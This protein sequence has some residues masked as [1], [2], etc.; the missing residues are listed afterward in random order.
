MSGGAPCVCAVNTNQNL[1][2][3]SRATVAASRMAASHWL[4]LGSVVTVLLH[5]TL[6]AS[7]DA[8]QQTLRHGVQ[9]HLAGPHGV[10]RWRAASQA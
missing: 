2:S 8:S 7:V 6:S 1:K 10:T 5:V 4:L 3:P 9:A